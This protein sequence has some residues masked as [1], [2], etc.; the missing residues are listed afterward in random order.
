MYLQGELF[1]R[2]CYLRVVATRSHRVVGQ[3]VYLVL[4]ALERE[5][6]VRELHLV[7]LLA[8]LGGRI[9]AYGNLL[10]QCIAAVRH[11]RKHDLDSICAF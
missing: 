10:G 7:G 5:Y 4:Q 11:L 8:I 2:Q 3:R 9:H 1:M 6:R